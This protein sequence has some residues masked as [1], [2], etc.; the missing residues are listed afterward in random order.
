[1]GQHSIGVDQQIDQ[2]REEMLYRCDGLKRLPYTILMFVWLL[3]CDPYMT[4]TFVTHYWES[5]RYLFK[6]FCVAFASIHTVVYKLSVWCMLKYIRLQFKPQLLNCFYLVYIGA[7]LSYLKMLGVYLNTIIIS[8]KFGSISSILN[9]IN[10]FWT[11]KNTTTTK[12]QI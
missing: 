1:M 2:Q 8:Y 4:L 11:N 9:L 7:F 6:R 12:Q 5:C 10:V 3:R